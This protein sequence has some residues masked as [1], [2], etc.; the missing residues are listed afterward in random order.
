MK[1]IGEGK[2]ACGSDTQNTKLESPVIRTSGK[3]PAAAVT[4]MQACAQGI[5]LSKLFSS[6]SD[7]Y[8]FGAAELTVFRQP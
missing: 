1:K 2:G 4:E 3:N 5:L 8:L 7:V 6:F